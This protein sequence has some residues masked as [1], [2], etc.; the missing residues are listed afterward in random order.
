MLTCRCLAAASSGN[1]WL[2]YDMA[3]SGRYKIFLTIKA[4]S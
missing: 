4:P 3:D 1:H 2:E